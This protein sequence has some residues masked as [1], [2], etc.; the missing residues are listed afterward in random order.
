VIDHRDA[1]GFARAVGAFDVGI[2]AAVP[3]GSEGEELAVRR[4]DLVTVVAFVEGQSGRYL[5][6]EVIDPDIPIP[7]AQHGQRELASVRRQLR[8]GVGPGL[9][10][11]GRG[12]S[13]PVHFEDRIVGH[14][15]DSADI[16]KSSRRREADLGSTVAA[17]V[18]HTLD[19]RRR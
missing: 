8:A 16:G 12:D 11:Q 2:L 4:P 9:V 5:A 3:V 19:H 15:D 7:V 17:V 18:G 6:F 14:A 13:L 10:P 1:L